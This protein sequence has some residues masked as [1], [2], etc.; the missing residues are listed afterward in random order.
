MS[1][2]G[3]EFEAE[4]GAATY[5]RALRTHWLL[6]VLIVA[7]A[8]GASAAYSFTA[9]KRYKASAD[10]LVTPLS[11]GDPTFVGIE[12]PLRET[13]TGRAVLTAARLLASP[14]TAAS[15]RRE[16]GVAW[17]RQRLLNAIAVTPLGQSNIVTVTA[18]ASTPALAARVANAFANALVRERSRVFR[19]ELAT[20]IV[21]L[22]AQLR[23]IPLPQ[24][25]VGEGAALAGR[26]GTLVPLLGQPD[27][28]VQVSAPAVAP[29][30]PS[31][32]RPVLSIGIAFIAAS[33]L[34]VA[35]ALALEFLNPRVTNE[36]E[37]VLRHRLPVLARVPR[38]PRRRVR[39]YLTGAAPLPGDVRE[40]YRLLRA[41]L[42]TAGPDGSFPQTI[43][44]TSAIPGEGKTMTSINL[45]STIA[46]TGL[47]VILVDGDLRRPM[48]ATVF[49]VAARR[50]AFADVLT[51]RASVD[52]ALI[53]APGAGEHLRLLLGAPEH[54]HV[55]DLLQPTRVEDV[56]AELKLHAD[57]VVIDSAPLTE[58]A[59][60]LAIAA[61]VDTVLLAVRL[62]RSRRDK[63]AELRRLLAGRGV[64]PVGFVETLKRR[65]RGAGYYY[66]NDATAAAASGRSTPAAAAEAPSPAAAGDDF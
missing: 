18:T 59:D 64:A 7:V 22:R 26:L 37:L 33:M 11:S 35:L 38:M 27:P 57:V 58:V 61:D 44:V 54:A 50:A 9:A 13:Q 56:L 39:A 46:S 66:G 29:S 12:G 24:R 60:A 45:A 41:T 23:A 16:L 42:A 21:G 53:A 14:V 63:L 43:L 8:A 55:I 40:A 28:T 6:V 4:Q 15:A 1:A 30:A 19:R 65:S 32:P 10:V 25:G 52:S 5:L 2:R 36:E 31:W 17:S 3:V 34:G 49:G 48:I 51:G 47:R 62:G 20:L